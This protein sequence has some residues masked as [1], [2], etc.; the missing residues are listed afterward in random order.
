MKDKPD[1]KKTLIVVEDDADDQ[2]F[3]QTAFQQ[4][5][6][7]QHV[8]YIDS[9]KQLFEYLETEGPQ[10]GYPYAILVDYNMPVM[11]GEETLIKLRENKE[12]SG[13]RV[14][15]Y[16]TTISDTQVKSLKDLGA[17]GCYIKS[18]STSEI[19]DFAKFLQQ[20]IAKA[21]FR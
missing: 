9:A 11:N 4:T 18:Y 1:T 2:Y 7:D 5:G 15:I 8:L 14:L 21:V 10:S 12:Y 6:F 20:K 19:V 16:S 17:E 13:I 3:L